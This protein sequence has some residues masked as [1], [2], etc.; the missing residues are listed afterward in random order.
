MSAQSTLMTAVKATERG[1]FEYLPKPFDLKE[2]SSIVQRAL[3]EPRIHSAVE[4]PGEIDEQLPL[5]GRSPAMQEIYRVLARPMNTDLTVM[6][7]GESGTGTELV[8]RALHEYGRRRTRPFVPVTL[9][10]HHRAPPES[11]LLAP[12]KDALTP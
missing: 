10:A 5:I 7:V 1:A 9:P 3:T 12:A 8:A 2:L 4:A 6:I 11:A